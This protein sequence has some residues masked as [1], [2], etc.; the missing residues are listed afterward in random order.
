MSVRAR[1]VHV[2]GIGGIGLSAIARVLLA[3]GYEV[4]GSDANRSEITD[5]L[6]RLGAQVT[7]GHRA[8]NV[9][10]CDLVLVTSAAPADNPELVEARRR[11]IPIVKRSDFFSEL[12]AGMDTIAVAGTHGKTTTTGM[13]ATILADAGLDPTAVVGG[14][15]PELGSNARVGRGRY[16]VVEADEYDRAFLGLRPRIAVVTS[17][18][19]DHPDCYRN[20]DEIADSFHD[21]LSTVPAD[22]LIVG[23]GDA[24]R[25]TQEL[26]RISGPKMMRYGLNGYNDW[27]ATGI[28]QQVNRGS[29]FQVIHG[30]SSLGEFD[31]QVPGLHNILNA[32]AALAVADH[33][34]VD[35]ASARATLSR[36][37]GAARRFEVKGEFGGVIIVDDYAHHPTEI[38][39]TLAAARSRYPGRALWAVF[40][41]HTFSRTRALLDEFANAFADADH[42]LVTEVYAARERESFGTSGAQIVERMNHP[43]ASYVRT[44]D[45]C[46][47]FLDKH[48]RAGDVLITLGAGDVNRVATRVATAR[49]GA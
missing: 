31:L 35:R 2:I 43:D 19:M 47:L 1:R 34:G 3:R 36:F 8:E 27:R 25:V 5:E 42:V 39:A 7:I 29:T 22:G 28:Q 10:N 12:T 16:F 37:R 14:I 21:L 46:A 11:G 26:V 4:S 33:L 15:I 44:L 32:L 13:I 48:L 23:C 45:G 40:Q 17:I 18:E 49:Q 24:E 9:G 6:E 41:P 20:V 30:S 38:R